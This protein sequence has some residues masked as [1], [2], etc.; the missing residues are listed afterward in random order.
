MQ[1]AAATLLTKKA[2]SFLEDGLDRLVERTYCAS[3][4]GAL[5]CAAA[6]VEM[7]TLV[8][9]TDQSATDWRRDHA[10]TTLSGL[11]IKTVESDEEQPLCFSKVTAA[12]DGGILLTPGNNCEGGDPLP[13]G[14]LLWLADRVRSVA[15]DAA[16]RLNAGQRI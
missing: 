11:G 16:G 13:E 8:P 14:S 10:I 1:R 4:P 9:D 15:A 6:E 7:N 12:I 3:C 2:R 5:L